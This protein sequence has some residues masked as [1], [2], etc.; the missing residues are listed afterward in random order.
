MKIE[1]KAISAGE[2]QVGD[3]IDGS[4]VIGRQEMP[5]GRIVEI[6][7]V[8]GSVEGFFIDEQVTRK[9]N[10]FEVGKCEK[11]ADKDVELIEVDKDD[12]SVYYWNGEIWKQSNRPVVRKVC[13]FCR[14]G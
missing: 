11:C 13:G 10:V 5:C 7:F 14:R 4:E 12:F 1:V 2:I 6:T 8:D 3:V 9:R